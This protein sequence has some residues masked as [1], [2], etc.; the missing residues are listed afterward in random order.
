MGFWDSLKAA[1]GIEDASESRAR[2]AVARRVSA[3]RSFTVL[4]IADETTRHLTGRTAGDIASASRA[5]ERVLDGAWLAVTGYVV[6]AGGIY[7]PPE[8][9]SNFAAAANATPPRSP[10]GAPVQTQ[11]GPAR[12]QPVS[13]PRA[14][15]A[16]PYATNGILGLSQEELRKRALQI[17][18][19][20][21][22]FIGRTDLIPPQS[23][24]RTAIIDR[25]LL[26]RGF[27]D[28]AQLAE[29]HRIGDL[30]LEHKDKEGHLRSVGAQAGNAAV[31]AIRRQKAEA[32]AQKRR[33]AEA[34]RQAEAAGVAKRK[35]EDITFLGPG[36]S[37]GLADRRS[38]VE[39]LE[40]RGLPVLATPADV[41][42]ALG[43]AVPKLRWL[44]FHAVATERPHYVYFEVP[45]R[46]G[47]KRLLSAP[48]AKLAKAQA[49][50]LHEI[51]EKLTTE[52]P[53]HGFVKGR[54]TVSCAAPHVGRDL[55]VNQDLADYFPSITFP[56]V[57][58]VFE[59]QGYSPAAATVLALLCTESPRRK[60]EFAGRTYFAAVGP[61]ALPQGACTS[62]AISNQ[63]S[64]RLDRRLVA[65]AAKHGWAFTRY[66]DDLTFSAPEGRR[67]SVA[68][69]LARVRH[70]VQDEGFALNPKKGRVQRA[71]GRQLV[72]GIVV[73]DRLAVP[74]EEVRRLRAIL[75]G[76]RKTGLAAQNRE[77]HPYFEAWLRG[78]IAY[79]A[80]VDREKG[81]A[82]LRELD[83]VTA[84]GRA[85]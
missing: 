35:A 54:S 14:P 32:K 41:A 43:I 63:V 17:T 68:M 49:W 73:N 76:A 30:W 1:F 55:V 61:R 50:V 70:V 15:Q 60:V 59:R 80:M 29:I 45:K 56:R 34:R 62:P 75:H 48:H 65:M 72:T 77:N 18:P 26:L 83:A 6:A 13:P 82:M 23:D 31:E 81:L 64:R 53:A 12:S 85:A 7:H 9:A 36:V 46:S 19:W 66:A 44:C 74:R 22:A 52:E 84:T 42:R 78:K 10:S 27:L 37:A 24:D 20:R 8:K 5:T 11:S 38:N 40:K 25:G 67:E 21:T 39:L 71:A 4:E 79:V 2:E 51:L 47:G 58:G 33:D 28:E 16:N 57:R 3:R 69:L